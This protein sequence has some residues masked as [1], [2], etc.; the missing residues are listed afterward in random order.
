MPRSNWV[1]REA[2]VKQAEPAIDLQNGRKGEVK[3]CLSRHDLKCKHNEKK[4]G[5]G[6]RIA[7]LLIG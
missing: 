7:E 1:F 3:C 4:E 6:D 2:S 5:L